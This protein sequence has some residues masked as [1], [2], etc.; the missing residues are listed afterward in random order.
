[1][2]PENTTTATPEDDLRSSLEEAF[3]Q[4]ASET[5]D[6]A[7]EPET[8]AQES[9]VEDEKPSETDE[10]AAKTEEKTS[11]KDEID[12]NSSK[13]DEESEKKPFVEVKKPNQPPQTK[14]DAP[15]PDQENENQQY[16]VEKAPAGWKPSVREH[17]EGL[18]D[19]VKQEVVKREREIDEK[20]RET[21]QA[22]QFAQAVNQTIQPYQHFIKAE[23]GNPISAIDNLFSTAAMLRTGNAEQ[24]ANLVAQIT[25][26]F[27]IHR[28]GKQ[29]FIQTLDRSLAGVAPKEDT[30]EIAAL[31]QQYEQELTPLRQMREQFQQQQHYQQQQAQQATQ[32]ELQQFASQAEFMEDVRADMAD[33]LDLAA[34]KG[35]SMTLQEAYDRACWA[36]PEIRTVLTKRQQAEQ[37]QQVNE[38]TQKA[39]R[40]AV[41][42]HGSAPP[43][44]TQAPAGTGSI[45]DDLEFA[46][47]RLSN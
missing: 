14:E 33:L 38:T 47:S 15:A 2:P 8:P 39:K 40:A 46:I 24:V 43:A 44:H 37:A 27:G 18:P 3:E 17:W 5:E 9:T 10:N 32:A 6:Q 20:L 34:Q 36:N 28:F 22:R 7:P 12:K 30:P 19:D 1:M 42:V 23:G 31:K 29:S 25:N 13:T 16:N 11:L 45:R 21:A 41:S 4:K 26:Q 35:Q